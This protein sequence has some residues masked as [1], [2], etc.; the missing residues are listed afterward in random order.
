MGKTSIE[1]CDY[2]W[3]VVNGC[4]R[5]SAGCENCYAER[6]TA[7]RLSQT[8][9][10]KGLAVFGKNGPRWTGEKRLWDPHLDMPV[11][12]KKP[13]RIFVCDMGDLFFEEVRDEEI[14]AV[15][16]VMAACPQHTF[17]V[18][19]KRPG[20]AR[21]WFRWLERFAGRTTPRAACVS[22]AQRRCEHPSLRKLDDHAFWTWPLPN[23]WLGTSVE[24]QATADERVPIL[25]DTPAAL[26]FVSAEPLLGPVDLMRY[27]RP[28]HTAVVKTPPEGKA[29][30]LEQ[31]ERLAES[32][33]MQVPRGMDVEIIPGVGLDWVIVG[34]ESGPGA[35]P[36]DLAWAWSMVD[37]CVA[38]HVPCFVKQLGANP[39]TVTRSTSNV[40]IQGEAVSL[41]LKDRKGGD[42]AEWPEDLRVRQF[43]TVIGA[44]ETVAAVETA[45]TE[46]TATEQ[47]VESC[48][49]SP[50]RTGTAELIQAALGP[51]RPLNRAEL[52][53]DTGATDSAVASCLT[54]LRR[55]GVV[56][57]EDGF[58]TLVANAEQPGDLESEVTPGG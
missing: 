12:L 49:P 13:S 41:R 39:G 47:P 38:A 26:R 16:G 31:I 5:V 11:R 35:R 34:G 43:P 56:Q 27:L 18:L 29:A 36:F 37:A 14:A 20:R 19:T 53:E 50:G 6:L 24:D 42:P 1:W 32:P 52:A 55:Q 51:G 22:L 30:F 2:S 45:C 58:W 28:M 44:V 40:G 7:T 23:V 25:L 9:K 15:F 4:R 21:A 54:R 17:Q 10:Y 8:P 33:I 46:R 57:V 48:P 3:P